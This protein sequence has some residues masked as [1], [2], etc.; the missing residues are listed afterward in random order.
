MDSE[1]GADVDEHVVREE[2]Q[3]EKAPQREFES[4]A[5]RYRRRTRGRRPEVVADERSGSVI[6][7]RGVPFASGRRTETRSRSRPRDRRAPAAPRTPRASTAQRGRTLPP[8]RPAGCCPLLCF[9]SGEERPPQPSP[10]AARTIFRVDRGNGMAVRFYDQYLVGVAI[11]WCACA[12]PAS[13]R[14]AL[15][16]PGTPARE[17]RRIASRNTRVR[18]GISRRPGNTA[19]ASTGGQLPI[20]QH[21]HQLAGPHVRLAK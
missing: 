1:V 8:R 16:S 4:R 3:V 14:T 7:K 2:V 12:R 17:L 15:R 18:A 13:P 11:R 20:G 21:R 9:Q 6:L 5:P 19:H 10:G